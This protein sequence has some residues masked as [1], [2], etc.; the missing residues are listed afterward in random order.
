MISETNLSPVDAG[1]LLN[2]LPTGIALLDNGGTIIEANATFLAAVG[3]ASDELPPFRELFGA[4]PND[5]ADAGRTVAI[6][7]RHF[8]I[9]LH[10][11]AEIGAVCHLHE[12]TDWVIDQ[13]NTRRS[14]H[15][16]ALT[17]LSNRA[18]F[19]PELSNAAEGRN[20]VAL[21]TVDLDDFKG[22]ND[23]LGHP[24]GD[25]L[26]AKVS[27]RLSSALRKTDRL[28]RLGGDEFAILQT[29][30]AQP[31]GAETLAKRLVDLIGRPY[32][33]QSHMIDIGASVGVALS[34]AAR[35]ADE[36]MKQ[37]DIALY[38]AKKEGRNTYRFFEE[39]MDAEMQER[40]AMELDLRRALPFRQFE[41]HYQPQM[42]LK[43]KA[44]TGMEALIRWQHPTLGAIPPDRFIPLAEQ[45]GLI[46]PIGEWVIRQA[47]EDAALWPS[48]VV[49]AIN[50]SAK[51]LA[52]GKFVNTVMNALAHSGLRPDRLEVEITES[53]LMTNIEG[54]VATLHALRDLGIR[55]S[56]DDFGTGYS[57]LSYL[58]SFPFHTIKIDQSFVRSIAGEKSA[59]LI[60]AITAI[61]EH[62]GMGTIAEGVET[63]E[64]LD[65]VTTSGCNSAQGFL[66]SRPVPSGEVGALLDR[67]AIQPIDTRGPT[68]DAQPE[69]VGDPIENGLYRLVYYSQN[70]IMGLD[71][72]VEAAVQQILET[73]QRNNAAVAVTGALMFTDGLFAQ[74]LEGQQAE[75]ERVFERIQLDERHGEVHLL[76]FGPVE[77]R[78]FARWAMAFVGETHDSKNA[79]AHCADESGFDY[80]AASAD[81]M[82]SQLF[83][84]LTDEDRLSRKAA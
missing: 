21:L 82:T 76:S 83:R 48:D 62:L 28:A 27:E 70:M 53:V 56:M 26:L 16:D 67:L 46:I 29:D 20:T 31:E 69:D 72:E 32:V 35:D 74:I 7:E 81:E 79:F 78:I 33:L 77:S 66:F 36:L 51:Q 64:Q 1:L 57:S 30:V 65:H 49:V 44:V 40:R 73:S 25:A 59:G 12:V 75:V 2:A 6:G 80:E 11:I 71:E 63:S 34:D 54:C 50:V 47:C 4:G 24:V 39:S 14:S 19:L 55:I 37:A 17:G 15:T 10:P 43:T 9:R 60:R 8:S 61:G 42:N 58:Q 41:L 3:C 38:R 45:T 5:F 13:A 84:L 22:V 68:S 18:A 52:S 23:T